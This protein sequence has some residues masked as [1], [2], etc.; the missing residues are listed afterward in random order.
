M[1]TYSDRCIRRGIVIVCMRIKYKKRQLFFAIFIKVISCL[2]FIVFFTFLAYLMEA[3]LALLLYLACCLLFFAIDV[4][5]KNATSTMPTKTLRTSSHIFLN[6]CS[7]DLMLPSNFLM[8][9]TLKFRR[10]A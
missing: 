8:P 7:F 3:V 4:L 1:Y 9:F 10:A 6:A 5:I 2:C